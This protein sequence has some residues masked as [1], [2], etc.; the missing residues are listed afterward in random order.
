MSIIH[1]QNFDQSKNPDVV[2]DNDFENDDLVTFQHDSKTINLYYSQ[3]TKYSKHIRDSYLIEDVINR[4]PQEIQKLQEEYQ[5]LH[6]SIDYFFQLLQQNYEINKD[7]NLTY[8][9]CIDLLKISEY[10]KV[11]KLSYNIYQYIKD[12]KANVDFIIQMIQYEL[13]TAKETEEHSINIS[14]D[15]EHV[16]ASKIN[17]CLSNSKFKDLHIQI[18]HRVISKSSIDSIDSNKLFDIIINCISKYCVLFQFLDLQKLSEK[19][20]DD[21]CEIYSNSDEKTRQYFNYL[22]CNLNLIREMSKRKK[23]VEE[24]IASC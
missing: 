20:L 4:F 17:E 6:E 15:I 1:S 16:L 23:N 22:K 14:K 12:H 7:S 13:Q 5:L 8:I 21:L 10:L 9:H 11:R 2:G 18:I 19:Q 3:L 24:T